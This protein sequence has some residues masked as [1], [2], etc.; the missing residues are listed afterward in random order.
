[1][2]FKKGFII[3]VLLFSVLVVFMAYSVTFAEEKRLGERFMDAFDAKDSAEMRSI[4][5]K[6]RDEISNEIKIMV[7]YAVTEAEPEEMKYMLTV[8]KAMATI[9]KEEFGDDRLLKFVMANID[10][11]KIGGEKRA[12]SIPTDKIKAELADLGKGEWR[13]MNIKIDE[14][15][16]VKVEIELKEKE[17]GP[18]AEKSITFAVAQKAKEIVLKYIPNAKGKIEWIRGGMGMKAVLIE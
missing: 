2:K 14:N 5:K 13:V 9:Y 7:E 8:T 16:N 1:M 10:K 3:L 15:N 18:F 4:I 6:N 12:P 11:A 17:G